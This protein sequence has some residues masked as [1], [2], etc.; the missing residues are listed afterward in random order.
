MTV[1]IGVTS[2]L[3][4]SVASPF[5]PWIPLWQLTHSSSDETVFT[6]D[7][8]YSFKCISDSAECRDDLHYLLTNRYVG[9]EIVPALDMQPCN[10]KGL[11]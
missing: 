4:S 3:P 10:A 5:P 11:K 6:Q 7:T 8:R 2:D 9:D 1:L